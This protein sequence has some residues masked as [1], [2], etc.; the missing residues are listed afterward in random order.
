MNIICAYPVNIDAV[1]NVQ[2]NE[3]SVLIQSDLDLKS[4]KESIRSIQDLLSSLIFCMQQGSG[5]EILIQSRAVARQIEESFSW[6]FRLGGNAGIMANV[7]ATLGAR[8]VLNAP[9]LG[10]RLAGMLRAGVSVPSAE[11]AELDGGAEEPK[12][13]QAIAQ[14]G[15]Q[16]RDQAKDLDKETEMVHFVF[17][18]KKGDAILCGQSRITALS[19]NRF[20][21]TYDTVNTRLITSRHFDNYCL[22]N[23][24]ETDGALLS[25]F[26]LAPL[27]GYQDIFSQ[28]IAQIKSWKDKNPQIFIHAEMGSFQSHEIMQSLLLLL[29]KIPVDSLGLNE[30][31]LAGAEGLVPGSLPARW[32]DTMQAAERLRE[33]LGLFRVAVHTRDYI[34]SVML[35]GMITA[36][37]E[38]FALQGGVEAAAALAATGS[39]TGEPPGETNPVGLKAKEEFCRKGATASGRGAYLQTDD[40]IRSLMP[41]LVVHKPKITVG[42][43][44]TATAT[45]FFQELSAI[46][47]NRV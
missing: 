18:F 32:Q 38:L 1:Y 16:A 35:R 21:A 44:D 3:I 28:K 5:A 30:D 20:I 41:S 31:E 19:D 33:R 22:E 6:Q 11:T 9:A 37:E 23:I 42:L 39:A 34:L 25:G 12:A 45:I 43:G 29:P 26:H 13:N 36:R 47:K 7:L 27:N 10:P 4:K 17:Q 46:R 40:E 24:R 2:G 15:D 8:P 14:I